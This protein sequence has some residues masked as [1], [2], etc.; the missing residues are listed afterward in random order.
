MNAM[1]GLKRAALA[2]CLV[3]VGLALGGCRENEQDRVLLFEQGKYLGKADRPLSESQVDEL[4][5]RA[6]LQR[7][8]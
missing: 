6:E 7:T 2:G 5:H 1:D 3:A 8:Q 4:R